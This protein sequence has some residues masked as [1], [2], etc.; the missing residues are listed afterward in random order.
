MVVFG[1]TG[2]GKTS[3][4]LEMIGQD[5][6]NGKGIGFIDPHGDA[7]EKAAMLVPKEREDDVIYIDPYNFEKPFAI[8]LMELSPNLSVNDTY[9]EKERITEN[10]ISLFRRICAS[11]FSKS[12][13]DAFRIEHI[14]RNTIR[15]AFYIKD[16]TLFTI[17]DLLE[18]QAL[19]KET[20]AKIDDDRLQKF[21]KNEYGRAGDY[22]VVKM[23]GPVTARIGRFL[24]SEAAKR[25]FD[26][27][28]STIDFDWIMD[29][30]KILI[31]NLSKGKLGED[32]SQVLGTTFITKI[33]LAAMRRAKIPEDDRVD[34]YLY[35]DEFQ[36]YATES[37][38]DMLSEARK[39]KLNLIIVEQS[40]S[41]Q[42]ERSYIGRIL[43]N[44]TTLICFRTGNPDDEKIMLGQFRG[45]I[46]EGEIMNLPWFHFFIKISGRNPQEPF[47]GETFTPKIKYD[48]EKLERII[49]KS[50]DKYSTTYTPKKA[51]TTA[52]EKNTNKNN[53]KHSKWKKKKST[54]RYQP[55]KK[56]GLPK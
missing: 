19:L 16:C 49:K 11:E 48:K 37:F 51:D 41:Q 18:D 36:N 14:L 27:I 35:V 3:L 53:E 52:Q 21:W 2:N 4:I 29:N 42:E 38:V 32:I 15:T 6:K 26:H 45:F 54:P 50:Q 30:E 13:N 25:I 23:I 31:A 1:G 56:S 5:M 10:I 20:V 34:F 17:Y 28:R 43:A 24:N 8:N 12:G 7:A 9:R 33:Q 39:Y 55:K 44:V 22:Q 47:T 46:K 40:T